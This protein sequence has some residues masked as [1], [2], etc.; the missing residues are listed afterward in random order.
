MP[1][2]PTMCDL[3]KHAILLWNINL[4]VAIKF[5]VYVSW[6]TQAIVISASEMNKCSTLK[7]DHSCKM[8]SIEQKKFFR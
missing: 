7:T 8:V 4:L 6:N 2:Y 3:N 1:M 5:H